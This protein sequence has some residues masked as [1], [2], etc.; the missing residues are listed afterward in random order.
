[1]AHRANFTMRRIFPSAE[2][3]LA[4][5]LVA[6]ACTVSPSLPGTLVKHGTVVRVESR[7]TN[8]GEATVLVTIA[9]ETEGSYE[10]D[11]R[12]YAMG[13]REAI[14]FGHTGKCVAVREHGLDL[15]LYPC[16]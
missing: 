8:T 14:M 13:S 4:A 1:L 15:D 6:A 2:I 16:E 12:E 3:T 11:T 7:I 9:Y 5:L 10:Q